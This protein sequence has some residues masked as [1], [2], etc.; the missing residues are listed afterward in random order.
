ME[1]R[2]GNTRGPCDLSIGDALRLR[3]LPQPLLDR[4]RLDEFFCSTRKGTEKVSLPPGEL[5]RHRLP[6]SGNRTIEPSFYARKCPET[7]HRCLRL[8]ASSAMLVA[9]AR[10]GRKRS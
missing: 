10:G 7:G 2:R 8:S 5:L 1:G 9:M 3:L 4:S 6:L